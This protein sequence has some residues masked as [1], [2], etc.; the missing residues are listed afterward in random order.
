MTNIGEYL[1]LIPSRISRRVRG[2]FSNQSNPGA[3]VETNPNSAF[4]NTPLSAVKEG[5]FKHTTSYFSYPS[6]NLK[7]KVVS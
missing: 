2:F 1:S 3:E 4:L 7:A 6:L 5:T